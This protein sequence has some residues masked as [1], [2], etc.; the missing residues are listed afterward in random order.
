M[1]A[2]AAICGLLVVVCASGCATPNVRGAGA[3]ARTSAADGDRW[4]A[5][6]KARHFWVS[7]FATSFVY[8]AARESNLRRDEAAAVAVGATF[9]LGAGKELHDK[10]RHGDFSWKDV[11]WNLIGAGVAVG[12]ARAAD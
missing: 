10:R 2:R 9:A 5:R 7:V 4:F 8:I 11:T 6:D 12:I 3:P 1:R